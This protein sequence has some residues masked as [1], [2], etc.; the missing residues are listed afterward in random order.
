MTKAPNVPDSFHT[1]DK[2]EKKQFLKILV[3]Q[4]EL[5]NRN[6]LNRFRNTKSF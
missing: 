3:S 6:K 1:E 2:Q 5:Q 4:E